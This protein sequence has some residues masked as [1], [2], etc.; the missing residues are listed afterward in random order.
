MKRI[1]NAKNGNVCAFTAGS[2]TLANSMILEGSLPFVK[3]YAAEVT[4]KPIAI[5]P[6]KSRSDKSDRA[7]VSTNHRARSLRV[8]KA[9]LA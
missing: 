2:E 6:T 3:K 9:K 4:T 8:M 1:K 7:I 5:T